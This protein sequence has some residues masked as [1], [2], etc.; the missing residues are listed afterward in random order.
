MTRALD[1]ALEAGGR[2]RILVG[3]GGQVRQLRVDVFDE[4]APK[5]VE[6]DVAR[7]HDGGGVLILEQGQQQ[8]LKRCVF[9][10]TLACQ[11]QR[12]MQ[13]LFQTARE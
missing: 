12:L 11:R 5:H 2:L 3:A 7:A 10:M 1:D 4:I 6:I 9:L 8:V 13:G